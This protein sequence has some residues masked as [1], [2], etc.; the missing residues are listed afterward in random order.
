MFKKKKRKKSNKCEIIYFVLIWQQA[1][2]HSMFKNIVQLHQ[3]LYSYNVELYTVQSIQLSHK[4][5]TSGTCTINNYLYFPWLQ[6]LCSLSLVS[7]SHSLNFT[8]SRIKA[9][10]F[11]EI[12]VVINKKY[13]KLFLMI[14]N[15]LSFLQIT[16]KITNASQNNIIVC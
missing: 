10:T 3:N 5:C 1:T 11:N 14:K 8:I 16:S 2:E 13:V 9:W 12:F 7:F 15:G 4:P 6:Q